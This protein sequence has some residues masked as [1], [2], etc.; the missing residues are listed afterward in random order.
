MATK[1]LCRKCGQ[2][3]ASVAAFDAHR[4]GSFGEAIYKM[5]STGRSRHAIGHMPST[6]R[7]MA[8]QEIQD[9][10]M[11]QNDKGWWTL[12]QSVGNTAQQEEHETYIIET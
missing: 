9:L 12:P 5:S 3:F 6:R 7:C 1:S 8:P 4:T 10:G 11:T 2:I